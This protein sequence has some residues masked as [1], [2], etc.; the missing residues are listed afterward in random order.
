M[1]RQ[2]KKAHLQQKPAAQ[3]GFSL[4]ELMVGLVIGLLAT[5]VIVQVFSVFEG[6][7]R[8]T[9]GTSDAQTN[10]SIAL[11]SLQRN[12]QMAGYGIPLP[13]AD[14]ENSPL[15]CAAIPDFDPDNDAS[16]NNS[17][18]LFPL[19]I[20]DGAGNASDTITVRYS[21]TAMGAIPVRIV[22]A[23]SATS[24]T[25]MVITN[26]IGCS[27]NDI[28]LISNGTACTMTTVADANGNPN[29]LQNITLSATTPLGGPLANGSR[30]SCMGNWQ[31]YTYQIVNNELLLNG[32][33]IVSEVVNMQAQYGVSN[34]AN[35]NQVNEWVDATGATWAVPTVENRNR[36][37]AI[38]VAVVVRNGLLEK[39]VV[40][41]ACSST[42][43]ANP[44]GVC[45]WDGSLYGAAPAIDLSAT[46]NWQNYR[47][48]V[49]ETIIPLRNMLWSKEAV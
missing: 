1:M 44:T 10:G 18:N 27:N 3:S 34:A 11:L 7:K 41:A 20:Q 14:R 21:T 28:A 39:E 38:R 22:N 29:T 30:F 46:P 48:R 4:I 13:M 26:N 43:A 19:V 35:S 6:R 12:I 33:P 15:K 45:A 17:T 42:T 32:Q 49:F 40:S 2:H 36:I 25:G 16:T 47:Y 23:T 31:N 9:S 5:L 37:K 24:G 8:S